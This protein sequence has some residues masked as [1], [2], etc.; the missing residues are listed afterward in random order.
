MW[1]LRYGKPLQQPWGARGLSPS[2][3]DSYSQLLTEP[4]LHKTELQLKNH[5]IK[6]KV[7]TK[8]HYC[9]LLDDYLFIGITADNTY[10]KRSKK[11]I[12]GFFLFI[13]SL[14]FLF[15]PQSVFLIYIH[16]YIYL[17]SQGTDR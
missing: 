9:F 3:P 15:F 2:I 14:Q 4:L 1:K 17:S 7:Q 6:L 12:V 8:I 13:S 11:I 10:K 16:I 5:H